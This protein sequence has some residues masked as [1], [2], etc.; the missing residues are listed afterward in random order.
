M[1]TRALTLRAERW[2]DE[3]VLVGTG[4]LAAG[5]IFDQWTL[6]AG[7]GDVAV[8]ELQ[9]SLALVAT[10]ITTASVEA[11]GASII[12]GASN[13]DIIGIELFKKM[14]AASYSC[15]FSPDPLVLWRQME[16]LAIVHSDFDINASP[17]YT[18][19]ILIKCVRIR[20]QEPADSAPIRLVR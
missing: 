12:T 19:S 11:A 9:Y 5:E 8:M 14:G 1:T 16:N 3:V 7:L 2:L 20:T 18:A 17:T 10:P 15:Y 6:P 13:T 4:T